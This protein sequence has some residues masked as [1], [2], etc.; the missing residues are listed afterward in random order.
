MGT[1]RLQPRAIAVEHG[2]HVNV[3]VGIDSRAHDGVNMIGS[4]T[5]MYITV[6]GDRKRFV[7]RIDDGH[8]M[9]CV[10]HRDMALCF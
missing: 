8:W 7:R 5:R 6:E 2:L 3:A 10:D 1:E 9:E 4:G